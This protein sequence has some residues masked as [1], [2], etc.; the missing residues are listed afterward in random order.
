MAKFKDNSLHSHAISSKL[1]PKLSGK[2]ATL[3]AVN[4]RHIECVLKPKQKTV[5]QKQN[6]NHFIRLEYLLFEKKIKDCYI[7][8]RVTSGRFLQ[9]RSLNAQ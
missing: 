8:L 9:R 5:L 2:M 1:L 6:L 4:S 7:F 3:P